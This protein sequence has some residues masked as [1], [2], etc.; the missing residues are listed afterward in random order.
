MIRFGHDELPT[1][2]GLT[3]HSAELSF[4]QLSHAFYSTLKI[5]EVVQN[6]PE[7][8]TMDRWEMRPAY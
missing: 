1:R 5:P 7:I 8:G 3:L 2:V 4:V 6:E